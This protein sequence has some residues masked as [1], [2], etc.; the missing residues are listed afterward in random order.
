MPHAPSGLVPCGFSSAL[1]S[2]S[3]MSATR[4][5]ERLG[6]CVSATASACLKRTSRVLLEGL[7]GTLAMG[8]IVKHTCQTWEQTGSD[9]ETT[10]PS[11]GKFKTLTQ[12]YWTRTSASQMHTVINCFNPSHPHTVIRPTWKSTS[13]HKAAC[14]QGC[15]S[16]T[17]IQTQGLLL[18]MEASATFHGTRGAGRCW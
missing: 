6:F 14:V 4:T 2:G 12:T 16:A 13:S 1:I 3:D 17:S 9:E 15:Q 8:N 5:P 7:L 10:P 11:V 18:R